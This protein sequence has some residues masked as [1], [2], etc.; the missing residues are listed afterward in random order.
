MENK[1]L[2][3]TYFDEL[4]ERVSEKNLLN[5]SPIYGSIHIT[6]SIIAYIFGLSLIGQISPIWIILYFYILSVE[7]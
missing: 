6:L 7:L 1:E 2:Y 5:A 3:I 4:R